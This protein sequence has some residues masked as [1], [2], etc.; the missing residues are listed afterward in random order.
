VLEL[1]PGVPLGADST[2]L[3]LGAHCDDIEIGCG[4]T[5]RRLVEAHPDACFQWIVFSSNEERA[6]EARRAAGEFLRGAERVNVEVESFRDGFLPYEGGRVKD[7]FE[8]LKRR[9]RPDVVFTH[10][11]HDAHQD[12]RLLC[13]LTWNTFR[14]H[15]ILEYEVPKFDGDLGSPN[16]FVD[17]PEAVVAD[18]IRILEECYGSQHGRTWF[19]ERTFR[20]LLRLRGI[21]ANAPSGLAEAFYGRKLRLVV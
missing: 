14:D 13:E 19:D 1:V 6:A 20:A 7:H 15:L 8:A 10:Y 17:A 5:V 16:V 21:E 12:H 18:K 2:I 3:L 11:R 4:A 9:I